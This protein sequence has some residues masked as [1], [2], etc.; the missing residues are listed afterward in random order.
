MDSVLVLS[1]N[2]VFP[3]LFMM[4]VGIFFRAKGMLNESTIGQ[5][6][7]ICTSFFIPFLL[8]NNIYSADLRAAF[9]IEIFLFEVCCVISF[10]VLLYFLLPLFVKDRKLQYSLFAALQWP[11]CT[12]FGLPILTTLCGAEGQ[13]I[14]TIMIV[15]VAPLFSIGSVI[16]TELYGRNGKVNIL[17]LLRHVFS[18]PIL[19][20]SLFGIVLNLA[21]I[22][23]P[24]IFLIPIRTVAGLAAPLA[25]IMLGGFFTRSTMSGLSKYVMLGCALKLIVFPSIVL[26][27]A[28]LFGIQGLPLISLVVIFSSPSAVST[29]SIAEESFANRELSA[30]MVSFSSLLSV[31]TYFIWIVVLHWTNLF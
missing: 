24:N 11:N 27:A 20:G 5:L 22:S 1:L 28:L 25:L 30:L 9:R 12:M 13:A 19:L 23:L 8:F 7:R 18:T 15:T 3:L 14:G 6:N 31:L 26:F 17:H 2:T 4:L 16:L 29:F 21:N 10:F